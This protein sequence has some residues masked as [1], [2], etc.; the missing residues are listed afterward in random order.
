M[1]EQPTA[2][3][4]TGFCVNPFSAK[5][6]RGSCLPRTVSEASYGNVY[7]ERIA[8]HENAWKVGFKQKLDY[9]GSYNQ[10]VAGKYAEKDITWHDKDLIWRHTDIIWRHEDGE[11]VNVAQ[12]SGDRNVIC[13]VGFATNVS[14]RGF[15]RNPPVFRFL[16]M[17]CFV[18]PNMVATLRAF[19]AE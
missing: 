15:A 6:C 4:L 10:L 14:R 8:S 5:C 18:V 2:S 13:P 7:Y 1:A 12:Q 11:R 16:A 17:F 19:R 9:V 3:Y